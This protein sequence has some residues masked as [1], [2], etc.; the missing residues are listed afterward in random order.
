MAGSPAHEPGHAAD[1]DGGFERG[2]VGV[3][4]LLLREV[5]V[6]Q[7]IPSNYGTAV[8]SAVSSHSLAAIEC[9]TQPIM[10]ALK[11]EVTT[12]NSQG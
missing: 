11:T 7:D 1:L 2:Q 4:N 3:L 6:L 10:R 8:V 5:R 12:E 9:S